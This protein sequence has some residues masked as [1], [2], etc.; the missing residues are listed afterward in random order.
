MFL[1]EFSGSTELAGLTWNQNFNSEIL[2]VARDVNSRN[3]IS[4]VDWR[5]HT[6]DLD[7]AER[8]QV[9]STD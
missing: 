2:P 3:A 6:K 1:I 5:L 8:T 9:Y 7:T 4:T